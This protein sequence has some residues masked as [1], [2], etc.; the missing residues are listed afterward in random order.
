[1]FGSTTQH[2]VAVLRGG[3]RTWA[4]HR[5]TN[6]AHIVSY[7]SLRHEPEGAIAGIA[8]YLGLSADP[9]SVHRIA[10]E[11][12]LERMRSFS[13]R[14]GSLNRSRLVRDGGRVYDRE[15]M[16]H[17]HHVRNGE[18]GYGIRVLSGEQ[19]EAIDEVL[20]TEGFAFLR[21]LT[22]A[23]MSGQLEAAPITL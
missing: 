16:L 4:F 5:A 15:T 23:G 10:A 1:M 22:P 3:L 14:I 11:L 20:S 13:R 8:S 12:S 6:T 2:W 17:A 19:V 7:E 18:T 9:A 21:R